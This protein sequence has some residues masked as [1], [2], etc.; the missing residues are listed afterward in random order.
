MARQCPRDGCGNNKLG[1]ALNAN[2]DRARELRAPKKKKHARMH[3]ARDWPVRAWKSF[4][5]FPTRAQQALLPSL[6]RAHP[7]ICCP[8][9]PPAP[10]PCPLSLSSPHRCGCHCC[11]SC[12]LHSMTKSTSAA[13]ARRSFPTLSRPTASS[14]TAMRVA[15]WDSLP[16]TLTSVC[17]RRPV[18]VLDRCGGTHPPSPHSHPDADTSQPV[19]IVEIGAGHGKMSFLMAR[20]LMELRD[21]L[22][23]DVTFKYVM[24]D[25]TEHNLE[26]W[27]SHELLRHMVEQGVLDFALYS[28][29]SAAEHLRA[30][31]AHACR[32]TVQTLRRTRSCDL[33][34]PASRFGPA[35]WH[36]PWWPSATTFSTHC[37]RMHSAS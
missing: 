35:P 8:A 7:A 19:Y 20:R 6:C 16:T 17:P 14:R 21:L 27:R 4:S 36:T 24:T 25:F 29:L 32:P 3:L 12:R 31:A 37:G 34:C 1:Q 30:A 2:H 26:F 13:G 33:P 10:L 28:A 23:P 5:G 11:G 22:P 9:A 15:L 18:R